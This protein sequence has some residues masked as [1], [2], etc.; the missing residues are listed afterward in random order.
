MYKQMELI[1]SL[2]FLT[3]EGETTTPICF[4]LKQ[5]SACKYY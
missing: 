4:F 1:K 3:T 2:K 5:A